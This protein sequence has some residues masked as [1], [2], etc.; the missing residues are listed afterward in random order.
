MGEGGGKVYQSNSLVFLNAA[1]YIC[2]EITK[3]TFQHKI[4]YENLEHGLKVEEQLYITSSALNQRN[5]FLSTT[6]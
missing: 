2:R 3:R 5:V 1:R 4:A 6:F